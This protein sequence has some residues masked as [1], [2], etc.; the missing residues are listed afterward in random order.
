M[1]SKHRIDFKYLKC[2]LKRNG[3]SI[4][5]I[6]KETGISSRTIYN[7]INSQNPKI[8]NVEAIAGYFGL[9]F[10]DLLT[11]DER[12]WKSALKND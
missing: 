6:S 1:E 3:V 5:D 9:E 4:E 10:T 8:G 7:A 12:R 2:L 11:A